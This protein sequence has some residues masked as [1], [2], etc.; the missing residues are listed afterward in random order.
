MPSI[1]DIDQDVYDPDNHSRRVSVIGG[2][3]ESKQDDMI[4]AINKL[5]GFD[6]PV[7]D[8]IAL[9]YTGSNLTTVVYKVGATTVAT[10][11]LAYTGAVLDSITKS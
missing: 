11:T 10:L 5:R 8:N 4:T 7:Y 2:S 9:G 6:I 3:T 1:H